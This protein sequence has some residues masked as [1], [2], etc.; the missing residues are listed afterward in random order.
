MYQAKF[1]TLYIKSFLIS[2]PRYHYYP[3]FSDE[4]TE[5]KKDSVA[6]QGDRLR[7]AE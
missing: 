7:V 3:N 2:N 1:Q 6:W 5:A 4:E